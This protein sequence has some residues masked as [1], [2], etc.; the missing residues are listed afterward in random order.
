MNT[1]PNSATHENL[2]TLRAPLMQCKSL[3]ISIPALTRLSLMECRFRCHLSNLSFFS[4]N[5]VKPEDI[6][7]ISTTI[8]HIQNKPQTPNS[9]KYGICQCLQ[10]A[11]N[12]ISNKAWYLLLTPEAF[13]AHQARN[14]AVRVKH[15][16]RRI[17][18]K[19]Y[20]HIIFQSY[21]Y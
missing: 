9:S 6:P 13:N 11:V 21:N 3:I 7:F 18:S 2:K 14:H 5:P 15:V 20:I 4:S 12:D 19:H 16:K 17:K 1:G 8:A 10:S